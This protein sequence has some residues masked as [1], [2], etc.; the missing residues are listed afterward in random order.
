MTEDLGPE[1]QRAAAE[2]IERLL[3]DTLF[4]ARFRRDPAQA[5]RD[6]GLDELAEAMAPAA[7]GAMLT[8]EVRESR[9]SLA[10]VLMAAAMEGIGIY[11]FGRHV[12]P[13]L[14]EQAEAVGGVLSRVDL[15]AVQD[16]LTGLGAEDA[17]ARERTPAP[18][19]G[20]EPDEPGGKRPV[21]LV[22]RQDDADGGADGGTG[23]AAGGASDRG[24]GRAAG[25]ASE[26]GQGRASRE[27]E[28]GRAGGRAAAPV[29]AAP[30]PAPVV[31]APEPAPV[32]AAP[33]PPPVAA[34]V[35]GAAAAP[36]DANQFGVAGG[37]GAVSA[38]AQAVLANPNITLDETGRGDFA[39]GRIDPR[40]AT[41]LLQLADTH[42][43]SITATSSDHPSASAGGGSNHFFG[44]GI[45][46]GTIDGELVRPTSPAA[47]ELAGEL[48]ALDPAI[49]PTEIGTPFQIDA[50]G[51]FTDGN[52]QDHVH[53]AFDDPI[54][55]D[56]TPPAGVAGQ[57]AA[58]PPL[59]ATR[60]AG[61]PAGAPV[62]AGAP[63][64]PATGDADERFMAAAPARKLS[65]DERFLAVPPAAPASAAPA[66]PVAAAAPAVPVAAVVGPA[67]PT[68]EPGGGLAGVGP[69]GD[70]PGDRAPKEHIALWMAGRAEAAGL[71][72][73]LPVMAALVESGVQNL[74]HGHSS[75]VGYFQM[76]TELWDQ[77]P[78]KGYQTDPEKQ[79]QW[80][81]DHAGPLKEKFGSLPPTAENLGEWVADTE[82]PA[83]EFRGRYALRL[84]EARTL[85]EQG[86]QAV[87]AGG[88]AGGAGGAAAAGGAGIGGAVAGV[89]DG[90]GVGGGAAVVDAAAPAPALAAEPA[91]PAG[92]PP[93]PSHFGLD[94]KGGAL[95]PEA[96]ALLE[97]PNLTFDEVGVA[98]LKAGKIDPR[99]VALLGKLGQEHEITV[100]C[101]CS[102]HDRFTAGGSISN[103]SLGRGADIAAIDGEI[104]RPDSPAAREL[105]A[106]LL[107]IDAS[108]RPDEVGSPFQIG[109][110]GHFTD[111]AHQ[112]HLHVGFKTEIAPDF[113]PPADVAA[114]AAAPQLAAAPAAAPV[115]AAAEPAGS[116]T[117]RFL[118]VRAGAGAAP[119]REESFMPAAAAPGAPAAPGTPAPATPAA[120][121]APGTPAPATPAAPATPTPSSATPAPSS[122]PATPGPVSD[123]G[124]DAAAPVD[125]GGPGPQAAAA[126][127]EAKKYLGTPYL[128]GGETPETG[129]DCSGL[130][131]WAYKAAGI[132]IPRVAADQMQFEGGVKV[133]REDLRPGDLVGFADGSG[134]VHHIGMYL[135][136]DK[137]I[138]APHTGDVVRIASLGEPYYAGQFMGGLRLDAAAGAPPAAPATPVAAPAA[139]AVPAAPVPAAAAP[140]PAAA[141]EPR[142]GPRRSRTEEFM[143]LRVQED[144]FRRHT[145]TFM[146][147]IDPETAR[148][149]AASLAQAAG[150]APPADAAGAAATPASPASP[151]AADAASPAG[152]DPSSPAADPAS[153]TAGDPSSPAADLSSPLAGDAQTEPQPVGEPPPFA[154]EIAAAATAHD[155]DP[156]LLTALVNQESGFDPDAV[157]PAGAVGL[158]QLMP[159]TARGLGVTDPRDPV[160]SLDGGARYLRQMLDAFGGDERK[161]LAGYNAG[162][163]NVQRFGGI[164]P[165]PETQQYVKN[166]LAYA[167]THPWR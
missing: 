29:V 116:P 77:G 155:V 56:F 4:R 160:Q 89:V 83:E 39:A 59:D 38:E 142:P 130:L 47:R 157:S 24:T 153:P 146:R 141:P 42:T 53:F 37:G 78:Y 127:A 2:L 156:A 106:E 113:R 148:A 1:E 45:D 67:E 99:I 68:I 117:E 118:A 98:D 20:P 123:V 72:P 12:A 150:A 71:P 96:A 165:F 102:D 147:A 62:A 57:G 135:G 30:E 50:P 163:G 6:A 65:A 33:E 122:S 60:N 8:L 54:A 75:S 85:I 58:P 80:F 125:G 84:D 159:A 74:D 26:A 61:D 164:P 152:G 66:A 11:E 128:Y 48:A 111:S 27:D 63:P 44:R 79:I 93:D 86:R 81:V 145:E 108:I 151:P 28:G 15:P 25:G 143:A 73:E 76:L 154:T 104:V 167:Q 112:D 3:T 103:H 92:P 43:L 158:C 120:P 166:V 87:A 64:A 144:S 21:R 132:E 109:A 121:A 129:F 51:F 134:Y 40:V 49:R 140:V 19:P 22:D 69:Y 100:S 97:N 17:E 162:P 131:Q 34:P 16:L 105:V 91:V 107:E 149:H 32:V 46:I 82:R 139:P 136:D 124:A 23:R 36:I 101:M 52:H 9:S 119:S 133:G 115:P 31:A 95:T 7:G 14:R 110:P 137:F 126:I 88:V 94:G 114:P 55:S 35:N 70:Y 161:A 90:G 18:P 138:H 5:C 10:G 13:H 41:V